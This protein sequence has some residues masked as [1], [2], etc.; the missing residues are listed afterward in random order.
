M[1]NNLPG[2]R[3]TK[4]IQMHREVTTLYGR[5]AKAMVRKRRSPKWA[6]YFPIAIFSPDV[7][8]PTSQ[9]SGSTGNREQK[10]SHSSGPTGVTVPPGMNTPWLLIFWKPLSGCSRLPNMCGINQTG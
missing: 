7:P 6:G 3:D 5:L 4:V 1:F 10:T 9:N 8:V 2:K